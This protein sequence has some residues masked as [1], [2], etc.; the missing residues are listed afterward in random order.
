MSAT[1]KSTKTT[2]VINILKSLH[3]KCETKNAKSFTAWGSEISDMMW[4]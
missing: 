2:A 4:P 1:T 3:L